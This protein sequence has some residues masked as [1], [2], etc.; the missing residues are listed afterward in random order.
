ML[1]GVG[2]SG[3]Q[4]AE[5]WHGQA[6]GRPLQRTRE[7]VAVIR[8]ILRREQPLQF[9]GDYYQIPYAGP[10]AT[11]LGKPLKTILHPRADIPIYVAAIGP[12]NVALAA[13]IADGFLPIFWSP[14]HWEDAFGDAL[15]GVDFSSFDVAASVKVVVGDDVDACR[16]ELRPFFALYIG[17][18]GARRRNFYHDLAGRYGFP[19]AAD[20]IQ[21]HFLAGRRAEAAAA[22]P[23]A[24]I[25]EVALVGPRER[26]A[27]RLEAW[28]ASPVTT[29]NV[30]TTQH[31]ALDVMAELAG[32]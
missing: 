14:D 24:L 7:Y 21:D 4:V 6:Y 26:I 3:P 12:R 10:D 32:S 27:E 9:D 18:M 11:G 1:L 29:L 13:E 31:E 25:D 17:G 30:W 20:E 23:D 2:A 5:G 28:R 16:D 15:A 22:V 8:E 19:D